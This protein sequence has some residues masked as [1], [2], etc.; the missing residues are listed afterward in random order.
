MIQTS[1]SSKSNTIWPASKDLKSLKNDRTNKMLF[2]QDLQSNEL[3]NFHKTLPKDL[4]AT[5]IFVWK[6]R[7][8]R[9][10]DP[11]ALLS[12]NR[13]RDRVLPTYKEGTGYIALSTAC[14][15][16]LALF[17]DI[18]T[19][20]KSRVWKFGLYLAHRQLSLHPSGSHSSYTNCCAVFY[21]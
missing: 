10:S 5:C 1:C 12:M 4:Y 16:Y 3:Q 20:K 19:P 18:D 21:V 9:K 2:T 8:C 11:N 13:K 14:K 7:L 15:V 17:T 6:Y